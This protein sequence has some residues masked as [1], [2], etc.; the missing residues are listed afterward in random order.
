MINF[1]VL[2]SR[3]GIQSLVAL[4]N[5]KQWHVKAKLFCFLWI[6]II[7]SCSYKCWVKFPIQLFHFLTFFNRI[8]GAQVQKIELRKKTLRRG[9][10]FN[11][12]FFN[13]SRRT[14]HAQKIESCILTLAGIVTIYVTKCMFI[15]SKHVTSLYLH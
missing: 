6:I 13:E 2:Y 10:F 14:A 1:R 5:K 11:F 12:D 8:T 15:Y 7:F 4:D 9:I 3:E